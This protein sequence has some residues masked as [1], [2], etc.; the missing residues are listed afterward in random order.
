MLVDLCCGP[1]KRPGSVAIDI[2][3]APGIDIVHNLNITPWPL[4][5]NSVSSISCE[6]GL[7][8][9]LDVPAVMKECFRVLRP[10]GELSIVTP[11]FTCYN[12]YADPTHLR[13]L[14]A[15]WY[16]P[17]TAG[18]YLSSKDCVF[19][20][21]R[22]WVSFGGGLRAAIGEWLVRIHGLEK[23]EK[24]YAFRYPAMDVRTILVANK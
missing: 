22:A 19:A 1:R 4:E 10:G 15:F 16:R 20:V 9:L 23:W 8:H 7:E 13:H 11:H 21:K 6:Q 2:A 24:N 18:G 14:S 5:S 3:A 17:F 12:S